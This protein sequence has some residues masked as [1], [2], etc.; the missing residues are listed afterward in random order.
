MF[1]VNICMSGDETAINDGILLNQSISDDLNTSS[2]CLD[3]PTSSPSATPAN[4]LHDIDNGDTAVLC[5]SSS[6]T[7]GQPSTV[8]DE[9]TAAC[10]LLDNRFL[11]RRQASS[12]LLSPTCA[13]SPMS[14]VSSTSSSSTTM[15][16]GRSSATDSGLEK[17]QRKSS[18]KKALAP[19]I[20]N[21]HG[22]QRMFKFHYYSQY[23]DKAT[24][25]PDSSPCSI[26]AS[27]DTSEKTP[28]FSSSGCESD[29][30]PCKP[31]I[32][33]FSLQQQT[34]NW[35]DQ[36]KQQL[37]WTLPLTTPPEGSSQTTLLQAPPSAVKPVL[38]KAATPPVNTV[39]PTIVNKST[40]V[41]S[42]PTVL[43]PINQLINMPVQVS[44]V[45]APSV[46]CSPSKIVSTASGN[47]SEKRLVK[48]EDLTVK[49]LRNELKT[50]GMA[51]SGTK[52]MLL[53]RLKPHEETI[54][55]SL[56]TGQQQEEVE[57]EQDKQLQSTN[58][59]EQPVQS[60]ST[61]SSTAVDMQASP[62]KD[63]NSP[64]VMASFPN[65]ATMNPGLVCNGGGFTA[66]NIAAW[67]QAAAASMMGVQVPMFTP[68][69]PTTP[70]LLPTTSILQQ[71]Q[72]FVQLMADPRNWLPMQQMLQQQMLACSQNMLQA[73]ARVQQQ[74]QAVLFAFQQQHQQQPPNT[75]S[76]QVPS[77]ALLAVSPTVHSP[78]SDCSISTS[79]KSPSSLPPVTSSAAMS[80][81][82]MSSEELM[83]MQQQHQILQLHSAL[84][85]SQ[86]RLAEAEQQA[87]QQA[88]N[89]TTL[90]QQFL[91][92]MPL[93]QA[94][95]QEQQIYPATVSQIGNSGLTAPQTVSTSATLLQSPTVQQQQQQVLPS[96]SILQ[97]DL[98][99]G[100]KLPS[101][102][103]LPTSLGNRKQP[104]Q[105]AVV[106]DP[107]LGGSLE[108]APPQYYD[109]ATR[110]GR[111]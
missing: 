55:Q 83:L 35:Q 104:Q 109:Q 94:Y 36:Q 62:M 37:T 31:H 16:S 99:S 10:A 18:K 96:I 44:A 89:W 90:Q 52:P 13:L 59:S 66:S 101:P 80:V 71:Q 15:D 57:I 23:T 28:S 25:P 54:L 100:F 70:M 87:E 40:S 26:T 97:Q 8:L 78:T 53:E 38:N 81:K 29:N 98:R 12:T 43:P 42:G 14:C 60:S 93:N 61:S 2:N 103:C 20:L 86:Q 56:A 110:I 75:S 91:S 92:A 69:T 51:A 7:Y 102:L 33:S 95:Q 107:L 106:I 63:F 4:A 32:D 73:S 41:D 17:K 3:V 34:L 1:A 76:L 72:Q 108:K 48:L 24:G 50:R 74:Q 68:G 64:P 19:L 22:G 5:S 79:T 9:S 39:A 21:S 84:H 58:E 27:P 85:Q 30:S 11:L 65:F 67:Q 6:S 49:Q 77:S 45:P 111:V 88:K 105:H 46:V 82:E 47:G